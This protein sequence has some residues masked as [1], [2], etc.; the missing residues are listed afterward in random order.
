M[1]TIVP[2]LTTIVFLLFIS[3]SEDEQPSGPPPPPPP[4]KISV[5]GYG[6]LLESSYYKIWSDSSWEKFNRLITVN[7]VLYATTIDNHQNEFYYSEFGYAG[8]KPKGQPLL[9]FDSI[10]APLPETL[11]AMET[12]R[13][14]T[15]YTYGGNNYTVVTD[16]ILLDT[17]TVT[18]SFG[19][20]SSCLW[21]K[22]INRVAVNGYLQETDSRT[23]LAKGP[24]SIQYESH[25]EER[26]KMVRGRVNGQGWG[27]PYPKSQP[28]SPM[29]SPSNLSAIVLKPLL[30]G[31]VFEK[32]FVRLRTSFTETPKK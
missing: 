1:K 5:R 26:F 17:A 28:D 27:M 25:V 15:T 20:F 14:R 6:A 32:N 4:K 16:Q 10:P 2:Y 11:I 19:T 30:T 12:Y 13:R 21:F 31:N 9:L 24:S 23:W 18:V 8:V 22:T 29:L 7:R 3:C